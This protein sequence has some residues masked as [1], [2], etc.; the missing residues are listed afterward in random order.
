[1]PTLNLTEATK[2][3]YGNTEA[4]KLYKGDQQLYPIITDPVLLWLKGDDFTDSSSK[5]QAITNNNTVIE[6]AIKKYGTGSFNFNA[7]NR[8]LLIPTNALVT[9]AF[10]TA[11]LTIEWW[12]YQLNSTYG[13]IGVF[14]F[15]N[16]GVYAGSVLAEAA[17]GYLY[18]G[19]TRI[20]FFSGADITITSSLNQWTHYA[21]TLLD[22]NVSIFQ[23]G[24]LVTTTTRTIPTLNTTNLAVG[25]GSTNEGRYFRG[26]IESFCITKGRKYTANFNPETDT[27]LAYL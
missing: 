12:Q 6:T 5:A 13:Y 2:L 18:E 23:N 26:Y 14:Q 9:N 20:N 15:N 21:V 17:K 11:G 8:V 24:V 27:G 25:N 22:T 19:E 16:N 7:A 4:Q 1:M 10:I 3:Y